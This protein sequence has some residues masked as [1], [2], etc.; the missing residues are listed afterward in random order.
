M[1]SHFNSRRYWKL[2]NG[3]S[4]VC[5]TFIIFGPRKMNLFLLFPFHI[6]KEW[7]SETD[8]AH[9]FEICFFSIICWRMYLYTIRVVQGRTLG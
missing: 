2:S 1:I 3:M 5:Y 4:Y 9:F 6:Y 8:S 7:F